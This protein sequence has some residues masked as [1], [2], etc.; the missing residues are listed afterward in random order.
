MKARTPQWGGEV[1]AL[2]ASGF[3]GF[4]LGGLELHWLLALLAYWLTG[5]WLGSLGLYWLTG[6]LIYWLTNLLTY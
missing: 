3:T 2:L 6:L 1:R 5:F 4:W